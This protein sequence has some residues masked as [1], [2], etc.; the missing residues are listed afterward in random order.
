MSCSNQ[1]SSSIT[2]GNENGSQL[3]KKLFDLWMIKR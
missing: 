1:H 3:V 2:L